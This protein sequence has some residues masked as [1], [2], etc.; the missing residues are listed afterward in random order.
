[1]ITSRSIRLRSSFSACARVSPSA[2]PWVRLSP[3]LRF[4]RAPPEHH[5]PYQLTRPALSE[6]SKS[7]PLPYERLPAITHPGID[8]KGLP[9]HYPSWFSAS[10]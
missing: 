1:M 4:T 10:H 9:W 8:G 3:S 2:V 5:E 6:T 7:R